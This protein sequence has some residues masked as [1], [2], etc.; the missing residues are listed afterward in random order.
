MSEDHVC[1]LYCEGAVHAVLITAPA[2]VTLATIERWATCYGYVLHAA[3]REVEVDL[4]TVQ[5]KVV[6]HWDILTGA[7]RPYHASD[8]RPT[9][10]VWMVRVSLAPDRRASLER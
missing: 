10:V 6:T 5:A 1:T 3:R 7:V 2:A 8:A 4:A 9:D